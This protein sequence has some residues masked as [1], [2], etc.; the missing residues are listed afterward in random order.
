MHRLSTRSGDRERGN[1]IVSVLI[2]MA[3]TMVVITAVTSVMSGLDSA[4]T[5]QDR[6]NA[7]Q[8]A[9]AGIDQALYRIDAKVLPAATSGTYVP[10][11]AG[12]MV[13]GFT[14]TVTA[15]A[16]TF[17]VVAIQDPVG[18]D[19]RWKV[20]SVGT[21]PGGRQR[22]AIATI[23]ATRLFENAFFTLTKFSL[24]G[25]QFR[26][27]PVAY[28]SSTCPAASLTCEVRPAPGHLG[29]NGVFEGS[30]M[31]EM[32]EQWNGFAMYGRATQEAADE[33]CGG[34]ACGTFPEVIAVTEQL[35]IEDQL[36]SIE[37][38]RPDD[39]QSC[40]NGGTIAGGSVPAGDYVCN[41]LN[42]SGTITVSGTGDARFWITGAIN[43]ARNTV[44]NAGQRPR[45]FQLFQT[46]AI[47]ASPGSGGGTICDS[48]LWALVFA[49]R[50]TIDC[51]G[52]HQPEIYGAV[53][54]NLEDGDGNHFGFH[55]DIDSA[56]AV[57]DGRYRVKDWRECPVSVTDC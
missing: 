16:S 5:D 40:P 42:L 51:G 24:N 57:N 4:R 39:A 48:Q 12:G 14:E 52:I 49:P 33:A 15:G 46:G 20:R 30:S 9:N 31:D 32:A 55:W 38:L 11:V 13:T 37:D 44:V 3:A 2:A 23:E 41:N 17:Q 43:T 10:T 25:N 54:A 50:L 28:R 21:E 34:G 29:T 6:S 27:S 18:Q 56:D 1:V 22:Q 8:S 47:P 7:F 36:Q 35:R 19:T 26:S 45:R 53:V